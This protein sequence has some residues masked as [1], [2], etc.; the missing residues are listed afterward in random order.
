VKDLTEWFPSDPEVYHAGLRAMFGSA[1]PVEQ[2][3]TGGDDRELTDDR[4]LNEYYF[5]REGLRMTAPP[6]RRDAAP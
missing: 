4:P 2:H 1:A 6:E 5:L 3:L